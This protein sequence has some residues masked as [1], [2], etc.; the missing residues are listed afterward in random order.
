MKVTF[1]GHASLLIEAGGLR[2]LSDPWWR[3]PCFGAQWW[4][5][6]EPN[7]DVV[8]GQQLDYIY[9]SHGHED[10]FH[11]G[12]LKTLDRKA[13]LLVAKAS[14]VIP[15]AN[16]LGFDAIEVGPEAAYGLGNGV[17]CRILPTYGGDTLMTLTDGQET[18]VNL[19][20]SMHPLPTFLRSRFIR[21]IRRHHPAIDYLFCGYGVASHFP[22][23][24]SLPRIDRA[25]TAERR[26]LFFN[27][28]W[29][30][31]ASALRPRFAFP[32]AADMLLLE[33]DLLWANEPVWNARRPVQVFADRHPGSATVCLDIAPGFC[34]RE[35]NVESMR[36]REPLRI[37]DAVARLSGAVARANDY[38]PVREDGI[39]EV[40]AL[41]E[42]SIRARRR[43][44]E[45]FDGDYR[46][47]VRL[48]NS[49]RGLL[50]AKRG[51]GIEVTIA[52][53]VQS[54]GDIDLTYTTRLA[55]L[56][57][58]LTTPFGK[59]LLFVGSGGVFEY[60]SRSRLAD[61]LH[62]ELALTLSPFA[63]ADAR[64]VRRA[65]AWVKQALGREELDLYN[66]QR[67]I[68]PVSAVGTA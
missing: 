50:L 36:L 4:I 49:E 16:A 31:T 38:G 14:S 20:D 15:E 39:D 65:K 56:R 68:V 23:S 53:D 59:D 35:R 63:A 33:R 34:I 8:R 46:L 10:H 48:R 28:S 6:P 1:I 66:I 13:R 67:W 30:D 7:L 25:A 58:S 11:P 40:R 54:T 2:V 41:L 18:L 57:R 32:F 27:R 62:D 17:S 52:A 60:P 24:Y 44:F 22:N 21:R 55:Y 51:G 45:S 29:A 43:F 26:Q 47:L 61:R 5:Y 37:D 19:N 42:E 9:I 64:L 12:T 3:G